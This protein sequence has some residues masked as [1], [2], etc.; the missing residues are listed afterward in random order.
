MF[1]TEFAA[2]EA[3]FAAAAEAVGSRRKLFAEA[4]RHFRGLPAAE[5]PTLVELA[6]ELADDDADGLFQ[7][8]VDA[9]LGTIERLARERR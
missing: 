4:R 2:D 1:V 3:R 6:D 8:G 5:F 9:W 7:F